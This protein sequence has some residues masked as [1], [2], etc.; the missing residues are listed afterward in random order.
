MPVLRLHGVQESDTVSPDHA[1][2][3]HQEMPE[4][5]E[6]NG[7]CQVLHGM[8]RDSAYHIG[9]LSGVLRGESPAVDSRPALSTSDSILICYQKLSRSRDEAW[10]SLCRDKHHGWAVTG[11][12]ALRDTLPCVL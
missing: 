9:M 4:K 10:R 11:T 6:A 5:A 2:L 1:E 7:A 12:V 3:C 8:I